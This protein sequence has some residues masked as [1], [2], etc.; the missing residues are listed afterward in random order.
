ML[1]FTTQEFDVVHSG[2]SF[3]FVGKGQHFVRHVEAVGLASRTDAPGG[4]QNVNAAT[5]AEIEDCL[6]SFEFGQRGRVAAAE[7]GQQRF[8]RNLTGLRRMV[9]IGSD[10]IAELPRGSGA[11]A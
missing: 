11:A 6:S 7:R 9:K 5:G 2:P 1:D 10:R 3:V 8:L 4:E